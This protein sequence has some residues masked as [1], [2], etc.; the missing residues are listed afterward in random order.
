[1]QC[2]PSAKSSGNHPLLNSE[3]LKSKS[4]KVFFKQTLTSSKQTKAISK[5]FFVFAHVLL[6]ETM[7][8]TKNLFSTSSSNL[9]SF[10]TLSRKL[11]LLGKKRREYLIN[12]LRKQEVSEPESSEEEDDV[13]IDANPS[14]KTNPT[15]GSTSGSSS[16]VPEHHFDAKS[17]LQTLKQNNI[18]FYIKDSKDFDRID[19]NCTDECALHEIGKSSVNNIGFLIEKKRKPLKTESSQISLVEKRALFISEFDINQLIKIFESK[20]KLD[21]DDSSSNHIQHDDPSSSEASS[22][23]SS[24]SSVM[25]EEL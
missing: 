18:F 17:L 22:S 21:E 24:S 19:I 10:S 3:F 4:T 15:T 13:L 20:C 2:N 12:K 7:K 14:T 1:M 9:S 8:Q 5:S 25:F 23:S 6:K 16:C 11:I